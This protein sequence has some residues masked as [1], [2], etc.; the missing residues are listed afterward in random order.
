MGHAAGDPVG[1][2]GLDG[3]QRAGGAAE[4]APSRAAGSRAVRYLMM[5]AAAIVLVAAGGGAAV[6][7]H[8]A[9][10]SRPVITAVQPRAARGGGARPAA[11]QGGGGPAERGDDHGDHRQRHR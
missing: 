4:L 10:T 9:Q 5:L 7:L 1:L 6:A 3:E 2:A 8:Y 11:G